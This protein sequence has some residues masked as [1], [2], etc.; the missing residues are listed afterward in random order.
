MPGGTDST[1]APGQAQN[2]DHKGD[3]T[4]KPITSQEE[5]DARLK[6]RLARERAKFADYSELKAKAQQLEELEAS[7]AAALEAVEAEKAAVAEQAEQHKVEALRLRAALEHGLSLSDV[8]L[9]LT[10][11][12]EETIE[13]QAAAL[14]ARN[15]AAGKTRPPAPD[16]TQGRT[17]GTPATNADLFAQ[18]VKSQLP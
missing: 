9:F 12:D 5:L 10:G 6:D 3:D 14:A 18:V 1:T 4:F 11:T 7:H 17:S 2:P 8:E 13:K 15:D 16:P